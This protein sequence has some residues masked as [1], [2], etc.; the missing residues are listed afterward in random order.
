MK[1]VCVCVLVH[2]LRALAPPDGRRAAIKRLFRVGI[3]SLLSQKFLL[4]SSPA[5]HT[6][7]MS[8]YKEHINLMCS[9]SC[10]AQGNVS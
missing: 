7:A 8:G 10:S 9:L 2:D 1:C 5:A 6:D 4:K 3:R